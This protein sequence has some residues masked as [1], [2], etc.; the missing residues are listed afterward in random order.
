M[1]GEKNPPEDGE[2]QPKD[3]IAQQ[4]APPPESEPQEYLVGFGWPLLQPCGLQLRIPITKA[5][6]IPSTT[7][8]R[9]LNQR[10]VAWMRLAGR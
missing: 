3:T 9:S 4:G 1:E 6:S 5:N 8:A 7:Q 10:A 2:P